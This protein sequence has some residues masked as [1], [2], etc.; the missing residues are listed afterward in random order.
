[1]EETL[2]LL[3]QTEEMINESVRVEEDFIAVVKLV[4]CHNH[5]VEF[6]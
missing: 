6:P 4:K 2:A 3:R 1:M 5:P